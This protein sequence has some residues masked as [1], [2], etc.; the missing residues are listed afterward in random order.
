MSHRTI[1][2]T[3]IDTGVEIICE[4]FFLEI[5]MV[6]DEEYGRAKFVSPLS[7]L[8]DFNVNKF[9]YGCP[10]YMRT[11]E[12]VA[13]FIKVIGMSEYKIDDELMVGMTLEYKVLSNLQYLEEKQD[14]RN[15]RKL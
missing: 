5:V 2:L 9:K 10:F 3:D 15:R 6:L 1:I 11:N 12:L 13:P 8:R 4:Y 7:N 14:E